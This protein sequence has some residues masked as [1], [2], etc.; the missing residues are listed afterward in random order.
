MTAERREA[1]IAAGQAA[2]AAYF[3]AQTLEFKGDDLE[4]MAET[5]GHVDSLARGLL[6]R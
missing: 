5:M 6:S 3:D 2:M 1:L 4:A